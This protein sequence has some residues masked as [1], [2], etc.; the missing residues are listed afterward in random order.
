[1][2]P[3]DF[4]ASVRF[5]PRNNVA[6]STAWVRIQKLVVTYDLCKSSV[7]SSARLPN[8]LKINL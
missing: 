6:C 1:L 7:T 3:S 4:F 2:R 5:L 8:Y